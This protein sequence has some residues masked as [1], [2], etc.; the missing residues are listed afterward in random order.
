MKKAL[1]SSSCLWGGNA[2]GFFLL[3][4]GDIRQHH[5]AHSANHPCSD[6]WERSGNYDMSPW[7]NEWQSMFP[8]ENQEVKL[9]LG[10]TKH[11]ADVLVGR[12][13]IEFQHS[14]MPVKAFDDRN[15]FYFNPGYKVIWLFDLSD[16]YSD[17]SLSYVRKN[18]TL[19]FAWNNPNRL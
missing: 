4:K 14:I 13:V 16:L 12:T 15:N 9:A 7:H 5:F 17:G 10:E 18:G 2:E 11:R 3:I 8:K 19:E 1:R 6:S